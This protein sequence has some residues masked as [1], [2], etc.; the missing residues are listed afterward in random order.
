MKGW[1]MLA[2]ALPLALAACNA[3]GD[4]TTDGTRGQCA[5]GGALEDCPEAQRT[6][7]GACWRLVD[8]G[9]IPLASDN[10]GVFDWGTCVDR[11][12]SATADRERVV[13]DCIAAST[14]DALK[15]SG[16]PRRPDPNA[17][18][19]LRLGGL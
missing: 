7:E 16:D 6:P 15:T 17:M 8:C 3:G 10:G 14:C 4:D 11:L 13:I 18:Y 2:L 1:Y 19:C 5:A 12:E 9:A